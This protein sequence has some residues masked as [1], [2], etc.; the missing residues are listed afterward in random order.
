MSSSSTWNPE[1]VSS[2]GLEVKNSSQFELGLCAI[3]YIRMSQGMPPCKNKYLN[4]IFAL[5]QSSRR[6]SEL[7][8]PIEDTQDLLK[9]SPTQESSE[10]TP[11]IQGLHLNY[12]F[13]ESSSYSQM[14]DADGY[15]YFTK[16]V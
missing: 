9:C 6:L 10:S 11:R 2:I 3:S 13:D 15:V 1:T 12:S 7:T 16:N 4:Y 14:L 5:L 8:F